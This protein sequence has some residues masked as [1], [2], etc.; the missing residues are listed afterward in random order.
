MELEEFYKN[1]CSYSGKEIGFRADEVMEPK[2]GRVVVREYL[3]HPGAVVIVPVLDDNRLIFVKQF[4]YA[5][6]EFTLEFPAGKLEGT[7]KDLMTA[8]ER[9]LREETGYKAKT[10]EKI[11]AV[12]PSPSFNTE[13]LHLFKA[14]GLEKGIQDLDEDEFINIV[15]LDRDEVTTFTK[16]TSIIDAKT[17]L[18]IYLIGYSKP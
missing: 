16:S 8:A 1:V 6:K 11:G 9:E 3:S 15:I 4:R 14:S 10:L 13:V 12:Y 5:I 17:L 18:G 2:S 7:D